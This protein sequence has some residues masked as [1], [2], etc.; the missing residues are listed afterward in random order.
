MGL[1][2]LFGPRG[3]VLG[4]AVHKRYLALSTFP[5]CF[6][7][8]HAPGRPCE[9]G[10]HLV[11]GPGS[12]RKR[13]SHQ[14][15]CEPGSQAPLLPISSPCTRGARMRVPTGCRSESP[16]GETEL[17]MVPCSTDQK[18]PSSRRPFLE[19]SE[20]TVDVHGGWRPH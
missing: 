16:G 10:G 14:E 15:D 11:W 4:L 20:N 3:W 9:V 2:G 19:A 5:G 6:S 7:A 17:Q 8:G 12:C 18:M 1:A 13:F